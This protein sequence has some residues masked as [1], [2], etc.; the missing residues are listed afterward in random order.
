MAKK[1]KAKISKEERF[2]RRHYGAARSVL[3]NIGFTRLPSLSDREFTY[4][5]ST[6]DFDDVYINENVVLLIEHTISSVSKVG[7]HLKK[8]HLLFQKIDA[9]PLKFLDFFAERSKELAGN[10]EG[11]YHRDQMIVRIVYNTLNPPSSATRANVVE[12]KYL[13][14]PSLKYFEKITGIAKLSAAKEVLQFLDIDPDEVG[15]KGIFPK[16]GA[17]DPY[18]GSILPESSSGYPAGFKVVS[19]YAD[20]A[21]LL[22]R[23][24]VV[25]RDGWRGS[26]ESYQRMLQ[27]GKVEQ[28]RRKLKAEKTVFVNNLVATLPD[29]VH[30]VN[31]SGVTIDIST[32]K[33][34]SPVKISLPKSPNSVGIIDGQHRLYSYYVAKDDDPVIAN[35]R[36]HQNLLVTGII[37]P[38]G[39]SKAARERFEAGIFLNINSNQTNAPK[40]LRQE[41]ETILKPFESEAIAK[42]VMHR[43]A[44][45]GP[46][47]G[48]VQRYFFDQGLLKTTSIVS[49]GLAPLV[50]LSG[51]DSIFSTL[52]SAK[53]KALLIKD[54]AALDEY[55]EHCA[56]EVNQIL[57]AFKIRL[58]DAR[59]VTDKGVSGRVLTVTYINA[60]LI[61]LRVLIENK[62]STSTSSIVSKIDGIDSFGFKKYHSS[63]YNR[64]AQDI[65]AAYF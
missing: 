16:K 11:P 3:R 22:E 10:I 31:E 62:R 8:K 21:A 41:I 24:F 64:M 57:A 35:L 34:T 50:K 58:G 61:L 42:R 43:L 15:V 30:P 28:I 53:Q 27:K 47:E 40:A 45:K 38:S 12:P 51:E 20:P 4:E 44:E 39:Y 48:K 37:F 17:S 14:Y 13:D 25:R 60:F 5:G 56:S 6:G 65:F 54:E 29:S 19:F 52:Q 36:N 1:A 26:S 49:Y 55:I 2:R 63:Q 23:A 9:D 32:L 46:L 7:D 33:K 18:D 59:W